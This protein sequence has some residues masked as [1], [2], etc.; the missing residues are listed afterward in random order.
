MAMTKITARTI[1]KVV[2]YAEGVRSGTIPACRMV[3][4][5]VERWYADWERDDIYFDD[6]DFV[7]Y[8]KMCSLL[9]HFKGEFAGRMFK[10]EPWEL[11]CAANILG[12][13]RKDTGYRRYTYA[14]IEVPRKNGKTSFIATFGIYFLLFDGEPAAEVYAAAVDKEQAK[15]CFDTAKEFLLRADP[16]IAGMVNTYR[17]SIVCMET[18]SAFKPLTKDTKNK[19]GL[20]PYAALCDERHAWQTNEMLEVIKTGMGARRQP[21]CISI[22]TAGTDTSLPYYKDLLYLKDVLQGKVEKDNHFIFICE[23]DEG[24]NWN[25]ER[26]WFKANPNL[27]VSLSLAYMRSEYQEAKQKGGSTLAAFLT[28]NLDMWV[29]APETWIP[30]DDIVANSHEVPDLAG[31]ECYVGIDL[32]SKADISAVAF[33]FPACKAVRWLYF[34]PEDKVTDPSRGDRVDYRVWEEQGLLTVAPGKV[35]DEDWFVSR[36]LQE[37]DKYKVKA[38]AYDPW[39]MWNILSKFGRYQSVLM[40]YEQGI[41]NMSVPTKWLESAALQHTLD[42]GGNDISRWMFGNVVIYR[43]PNA[44][45]KLNK[46]KSRNKIDGIVALVDAIGGWLV[47][48]SGKSSQ[49]YSDHGLRVIPSL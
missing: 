31:Q 21:V 8:L 1:S 4:L 9:R 12:W 17:N 13:H 2:S 24:D 28:K 22:S 44:N 39:G 35:L 6:T 14:D 32:A 47:K 20:N 18:A 36:L 26:N 3:K 23:L 34:V 10:L 43:D 40:A 25:D 27:G 41:K 15:L 29:D 30:D 7:T 16:E 19:D 5:A 48:T 38:I 42:F 37:L 46:A 45:I 33:W 11:F 49:I